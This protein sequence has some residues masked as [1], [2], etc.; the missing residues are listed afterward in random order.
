VGPAPLQLAGTTAIAPDGSISGDGAAGCP[1]CWPQG[2]DACPSHS[3]AVFIDY[4]SWRGVADGDWDNNGVATGVNYGTRLGGISECT[5][6]GFQIGGSVGVFDWSGADYRLRNQTQA[7]TQGFIT[8]GFFRR[9]NADSPWSGAIVQDWMINDNFSVFAQTPTMWQWRWQI[10]Y[11]FSDCD[12]YGFWGAVRGAGDNRNV[13]FFGRVD[14]RAVDRTD[15]F[16]HHKWMYGADTRLSIGLPEDD[17][18]A[19]GGSLGSWLA[20]AWADVPLNDRI[21]LYT[22]VAYM[23]PSAK[24]GTAATMDEAWNFTVGLAFYPGGNARAATVAGDCWSPLIPV[25]NNGTFLVDA[26]RNY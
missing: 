22:L 1:N 26:S 9:A 3:L 8:Y 20:S 10:G 25:A 13:P 5:G 12:E 19:G 15:F 7:E 6:V 21:S 23:R 18:L 2:C 16:W 4:D 24:P 11:A 17:R 14:W